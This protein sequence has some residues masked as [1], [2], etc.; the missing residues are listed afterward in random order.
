MKIIP[1]LFTF[2][3]SLTMPAGVCMTSLLESAA[4]E[5]FYDIFILHRPGCDFSSLHVLENHFSNFRL[6]FREVSGEFVGAYEI[7]G[8]PETAYYR[9]LSPEL[10]PEYDKI[11]YSDVD[12]IIREDLSKYYEIDLGDNYFA[13][14]D[15]CSRLRPGMRDYIAGLGLDW[16]NGYYYSGN[17][18]INSELIRRDH[19]IDRFRELGKNDYNQQDMDII[20][21]ACNK[22]FLPLGPVF[23]LTVQLYSL[24]VNR[25][26]EME[27]IY[28]DE[29]LINALDHGIVHYNG[30]K[31][32]KGSCLNMDLWWAVYR[33]SPFFDE[34][35]CQRFWENQMTLLEQLPLIKRMKMVL[36]YPIDRKKFKK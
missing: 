19:M 34:T 11:I 30:S 22:R 6:T 29:A 23:C 20:N 33:R 35:Y 31:P 25:R 12:V 14:V 15:N 32:W 3:Q 28:G 7:R 27:A 10:I 16:K 21:I 13:A 4:P 9:L 5:T 36:R 2:D 18:I 1:I 26:E 24:I 17:L 8:I